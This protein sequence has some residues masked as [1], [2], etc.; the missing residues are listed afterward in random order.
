MTT[1]QNPSGFAIVIMCT[2]FLICAGCGGGDNDGNDADTETPLEDNAIVDFVDVHGM[3]TIDVSSHGS[4]TVDPDAIAVFHPSDVAQANRPVDYEF[5]DGLLSFTIKNLNP[6]GGDTVTVVLTF[7]TAYDSDARCYKVTNEGFEQF[8]SAI[9]SGNQVTLTLT[10]NGIGDSDSVLGQITDPLGLAIPVTTLHNLVN[11]QPMITPEMR[12]NTTTDWV[13]GHPDMIALNNGGYLVAWQSYDRDDDSF[14]IYAQRFDAAG[15]ALGAETRVNT[16]I[17]GMQIHP[18]VAKLRD[19]GYAITWLNPANNSA[20]NPGNLYVQRYNFGGIPEGSE[21]L[22][23]WG[24]GSHNSQG[25]AIA[26]LA[27]GGFVIAYH[28]QD[29]GGAGDY[30]TRSLGIAMQVFDSDG[31]RI[32]SET[33]VNTNIYEDQLNPSVAALDDG[34]YVVVW[35][36]LSSIF[37][38]HSQGDESYGIFFQRYD[39]NG[40]PVGSETHVNTTTEGRQ[41]DPFVAALDTGGF[42]VVWDYDWDPNDYDGPEIYAQRYNSSGEAV[43]S[44]TRVGDALSLG[45]LPVVS[46]FSDG[47]YIVAWQVFSR[48]GGE[49]DIRARCFYAS[50]SPMGDTFLVNVRTDDYQFF[51]SVAVLSDD[52]YIVAWQSEFGD[53]RFGD[54]YARRFRTE[55]GEEIVAT[56]HE[57]TTTTIDILPYAFD[58]DTDDVLSAYDCQR[59]SGSGS[60]SIVGDRIVFDPG[61]FYNYLGHGENATVRLACTV[62]D[63]S[64]ET[65]AVSEPAYV[66]I[67][68]TGLNDL[69]VVA[70]PVSASATEDDPQFNVNL[71]DNASDPDGDSLSVITLT[72]ERGDNSGVTVGTG[73]LNINPADYSYLDDGESSV[74][75]Y[76]YTVFDGMQGVDQTATITITGTDGEPGPGTGD[77]QVNTYT[78]GDQRGPS[79]AALSGGGYV[80]AWRSEGQDGDDDG[81]YFQRYNTDGSELGDETLV[82][83]TWEGRQWQSDVCGLTGGGYVIAW[84]DGGDTSDDNIYLQR[85]DESGEKVGS[86]T[87]V[88][89]TTTN[90]QS[91]PQ[92]AGLNDGDYVVIW[93]SSWDGSYNGVYAQR[94]DADGNTV[95]GETRVNTTTENYQT[96]NAITPLNDGGYLIVWSSRE[97][98]GD[99]NGV[100]YQRYDS[101]GITVG[102]ET[103]VNTTTV[104]SQWG[105][106][107]AALS[108]GGFVITWSSYEQDGSDYGIY[109]QRYDVDG[110]PVGSETLIN[111]ITS[112]QQ[113]FSDVTGLSGGGYV[114]TWLS[115]FQD[116]SAFGVYSQR[117]DADGNPLGTET[118]VNTTTEGDQNGCSIIAINGGGYIVTWESDGQDGDGYGVYLKQFDANGDVVTEP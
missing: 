92:V 21:T 44:E 102:N 41:E 38:E 60:V 105:A 2:L 89:T 15:T 85:F 116:G 77:I 114:V 63:D 53:N 61:T 29:D 68:I 19:G 56:G 110:N 87:R 96:P 42:V 59:A 13:Q 74:I 58:Q 8:G 9:I 49:Y 18:K 26:G 65:N 79:V 52:S 71:L 40:V 20:G 69:P 109:H 91:L 66:D 99:G 72:L 3:Y 36:S 100:Y 47:G 11:S 35:Q 94:Y 57:D 14:E 4:A 84:R 82:N 33:I 81:I 117:Y 25:H 101:S 93:S 43:G 83:T 55:G 88:N 51:P 112:N 97:Q 34:G 24:G 95:G 67:L 50:G 106:S 22:V 70:A 1:L 30:S 12:I 64:G 90:Y 39:S 48:T 86:E 16:T 6:D 80:V 7:P 31:E 108:D 115:M 45:S 104:D 78:T 10:D 32:V 75:E 107:A 28:L 23:G 98:D 76:S 118:Q 73:G 113:D 37:P 46:S 17:E 62:T 103:L 5:P 27:G 54:I 111:T